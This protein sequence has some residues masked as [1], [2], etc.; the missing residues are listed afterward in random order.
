MQ[1]RL[2]RAPGRRLSPMRHMQ[3]RV[4]TG[5]PSGTTFPSTGVSV[6]SRLA[7]ARHLRV[8]R[9]GGQGPCAVL[10]LH[11]APGCAE[12]WELVAR[13]LS[14]A[15]PKVQLL[16]FDRPG[17]G[18]SREGS[19]QGGYGYQIEAALGLLE[20]RGLV[21]DGTQLV[22]VGHSY[23]A[24]LAMGLAKRLEF[25]RCLAGMALVSGVI[26]PALS[27]R[28]WFHRLLRWSPVSIGLP[29][30]WR[31]SAEEMWEVDTYLNYAD[32]IWDNWEYPLGLVH[33]GAD[34][35]VS[36]ENSRSVAALLK[37]P[38]AKLSCVE[39]GG[40][41]LIRTHPREVAAEISQVLEWVRAGEDAR[42]G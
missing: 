30:G 21:S 40:H 3:T 10:F 7:I 33:G 35:V 36:I 19:A 20:S 31:R 12:N 28:R 22:L 17:Y 38:N 5:R 39:G 34:R 23:G 25:R 18:E 9:E 11:G 29:A 15:Q 6:E 8:L 14:A 4:S 2:Y 16:S 26:D 24:A 37:R 42:H 13:E 32:E 41:D 1:E 27:H